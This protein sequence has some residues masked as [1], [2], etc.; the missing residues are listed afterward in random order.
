VSPGATT[1][2][3]AR[4]NN[5]RYQD[6]AEAKR[7]R[8]TLHSDLQ[9]IHEQPFA[10]ADAEAEREKNGKSKAWGEDIDTALKSHDDAIKVGCSWA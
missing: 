1:G 8:E 10:D 5:G 4:P 9:L 7:R 6:S 3:V 2:G